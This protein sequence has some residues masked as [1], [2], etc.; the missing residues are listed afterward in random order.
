M[1]LAMDRR[2]TRR[3]CPGAAVLGRGVL[4]LALAHGPAHAAE[5][6]R[7]PGVLAAEGQAHR[8]AGDLAGAIDRWQQALAALPV[9]YKCTRDLYDLWNTTTR[10]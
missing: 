7:D 1:P 6:V 3:S 10:A 2:R 9:A 4:A 5:P 8:D